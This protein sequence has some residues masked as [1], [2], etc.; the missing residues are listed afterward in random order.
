MGV[1]LVGE[2]DDLYDP[3][4]AYAGDEDAC[5]VP[6]E[7]GLVLNVRMLPSGELVLAHCWAY[8]DMGFGSTQLFRRVREP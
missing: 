5:W 7:E 2:S 8:S 1:A 3:Y 4:A 6:R